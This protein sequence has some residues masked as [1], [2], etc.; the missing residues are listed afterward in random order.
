MLLQETHLLNIDHQKLC[1]PWIGRIFHSRFSQKTR[2]AAILIRKN[3]L[4]TPG[5]V[6]ADTNGRYIIVSGTL[7]QKPVVLVSVYTP[8]WDDH[9]FMKTFLSSLPNLNSH[10]LIMGGDMNCVIDP[11]LDKSSFKNVVPSRMARTVSAFMEQYGYIDPWRF[12]NPSAKQYSFL[13]HVHRT[14][15]RIDY[16]LIDKTFIS[17]IVSTQYSSIAV[18]DHS[19]VTLDLRFEL[20][21]KSYRSWH[22][23]PLL[24]SQ[25]DFC[26]QVS[27]AI[28][29]FW[30]LIDQM[31]HL[32]RCCGKL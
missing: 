7:Y 24:L 13:S 8:N 26:K 28:D 23:D 25:S 30:R 3:V 1:R 11:L 12:L 18:S 2:G 27:E 10:T 16:F 29:F 14:Y 20:K 9:A 19:S 15:S 4:F 32:L 21:H 17:S 6:F 22:L 31:T 5:D